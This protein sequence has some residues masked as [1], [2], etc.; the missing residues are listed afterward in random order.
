MVELL[1]ITPKADEQ[2]RKVM[3]VCYE[4]EVSLDG[5][6]KAIEAGHHAILEHAYATFKIRCSV[7]VLGQLTRHRHLSFM[8]KSTRAADFWLEDLYPLDELHDYVEQMERAI[9][10]YRELISCGVKKEDAAYMLPRALLTN[11]VVTGN[12]R[13]WFEYLPK[14][15]CQRAMLEHRKI[16][17]RIHTILIQECPKVFAVKL[18][19]CEN[20]KELSCK[21]H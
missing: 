19:N 3:G 15:L 20:C 9:I 12:F 10:D 16:A 13:A 17:E 1:Y 7:G 4:K 21:Y 11:V 14:R 18:L 8:V 2:I 5:M 6:C